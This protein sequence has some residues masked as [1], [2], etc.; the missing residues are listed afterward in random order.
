M[1]RDVNWTAVRAVVRKDLRIAFRN[2]GVRIPLLVTPALLLVVVPTFLVLGGQLLA[3]S[4]LADLPGAP[5][6][7]EGLLPDPADVRQG[8]A[9]SWERT[10]LEYLVAPLYLLV[11]LVVATVI[12]ADSFAGERERR[13]LEA[14]LHTGS[15]DQALFLGKFLAAYVP[16][17]AMSWISFA[18]YSILANLLGHRAAGGIFFPTPTWLV[19]AFWVAPGV[20]LLGIAV[21]VGVS[22]RVRSLQAAH[23]VGSLL[24]LPFL[25][26]VAVQV[27]GLMM[28]DV[29]TMVVFGGLL[30]LGGLA[31]L[32]FNLRTLDRDALA[33]RL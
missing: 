32:L 1:T 15:D 10:V 31:V 27:T 14:L 3:G 26:L 18:G 16:A 24:V 25:L 20:S 8:A 21:M 12:A 4:G 6:A 28:L 30:W 5:N 23:Q 22:S 29:T 7:F 9:L 13:T 2:R 11:P 33:S 17:I 19:I